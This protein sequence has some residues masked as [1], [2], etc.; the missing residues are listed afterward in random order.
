VA[1]Q[2]K[3]DTNLPR[4]IDGDFI[5]RVCKYYKVDYVPEPLVN[6]YVDHGEGRITNESEDG[7]RNAI[8]GQKTKLDKFDT[9][10]KEYP[11]RAAQIYAQIGIR[12]AQLQEWDNCI[13]FHRKAIM[14]AP[15]NTNVYKKIF[16][17]IKY[18]INR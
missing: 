4:G 8:N 16:R 1:K 10:L 5:R 13:K 6:Y 11:E 18:M 14:A 17:S 15:T 12:Y 9:E 3:L 7:I 2:F